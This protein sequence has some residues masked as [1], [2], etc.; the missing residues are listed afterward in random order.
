MKKFYEYEIVYDADE[1][2][3]SVCEKDGTFVRNLK[4]GTAVYSE[5]GE[6]NSTLK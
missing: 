5:T 6:V 4:D 1:L 3:I 2:T